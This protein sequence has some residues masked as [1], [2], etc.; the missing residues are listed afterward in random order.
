MHAYSIDIINQYIYLP[1]STGLHQREIEER[2]ELQKDDR[3]WMTKDACKPFPAPL[4]K[5]KAK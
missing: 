5:K 2:L 3:A 1:P 4:P